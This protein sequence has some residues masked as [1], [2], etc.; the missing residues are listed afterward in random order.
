[1]NQLFVQAVGFLAM[2]FCIGSY[3]V[4]IG[5]GLILCKTAGDLI[6]V[7]HYLMLGAY[8]GCVTLGVSAV[9]QIAC[10]FRGRKN[11]ADWKGWRWLFSALMIV[12]CLLVWR[13]SFRFSNLCAMVSMLSVTLTTWSGDAKIM[14]LNKLFIAGPA[15]IVYSVM[16]GSWSGILC[17]SIGMAS[18]ALAVFRYRR[19]VMTAKQ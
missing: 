17:E 16:A 15:W 13:G 11:W 6:Y 19:Q 9:S 1:M 3:Q 12:A 7:L 10:S 4:K 8:S 14:R 18:A 5:R 2:A